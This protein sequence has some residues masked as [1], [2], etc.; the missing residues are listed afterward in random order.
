[1]NAAERKGMMMGRRCPFGCEDPSPRR[2]IEL[3]DVVI[4]DDIR[5]VRKIAHA[6]ACSKCGFLALFVDEDEK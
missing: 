5:K 4:P 6:F 3:D 2:W 1:M